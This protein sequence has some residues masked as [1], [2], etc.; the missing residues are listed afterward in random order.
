MKYWLSLLCACLCMTVLKADVLWQDD[1]SS[2]TVG[3]QVAA[4]WGV[5]GSKNTSPVAVLH[6]GKTAVRIQDTSKKAETGITRN[7]HCGKARFIR[8]AVDVEA[9][10]GKSTAAPQLSLQ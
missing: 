7:F 6:Q 3:R 4:P 8:F 2:Q 1:F 10:P 9:L 5:Y